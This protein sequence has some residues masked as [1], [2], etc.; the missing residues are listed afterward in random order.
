MRDHIRSKS[1]TII[2]NQWTSEVHWGHRKTL[3]LLPI[4][5]SLEF[6]Y[7]HS[8]CHLPELQFSPPSYACSAQESPPPSSLSGIPS[9]FPPQGLCT[10]FYPCITF[11]LPHFISALPG[12][13]FTKSYLLANWIPG[14]FSY[15]F[16]RQMSESERGYVPFPTSCWLKVFCSPEL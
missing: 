11:T 5:H 13:I 6:S 7:S 12:F 3:H 16:C 15:P 4:E 8:H 9:S 2:F 10:C 1:E 14:S